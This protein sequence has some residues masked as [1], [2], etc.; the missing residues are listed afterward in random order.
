MKQLATIA[1]I[2]LAL[3][4]YLTSCG[5]NNQTLPTSELEERIQQ[6]EK[7]NEKIKKEAEETSFRQKKKSRTF[8]TN[9]RTVDYDKALNYAYTLGYEHGSGARTNPMP[10]YRY[11]KDMENYK[12]LWTSLYG[13]PTST[14]EAQEAYKACRERYIKGYN[15]AFYETN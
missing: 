9:L 5:G 3:A 14:S 4:V 1:G 7:E 12:G 15:E 6:L 2:G 8:T 13:V 11:E 10:S